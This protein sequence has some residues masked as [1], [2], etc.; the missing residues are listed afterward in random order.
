MPTVRVWDLPTRIFHALLVLAVV[1]LVVTAKIGGN[2]MEW[3]LRLG[4]AVL[5]LLLFRLLWGFLGGRWSR[6][7]QFIYRPAQVWAYLRGTGSPLHSIG[8]TPTGALSVF[9]MLGVLGAQV[10]SGLFSDDEIAFFGPL[11]RFVSADTVSLATHYHKAIGQWLLLGLIALH[12][13]AVAYYQW[14]RHQPLVG[15]MLHGDKPISPALG[16]VPAARD[17]WPQRLLALCLALCCIAVSAWV[18]G[19][20]TV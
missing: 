9:A 11:T 16:Q 13:L 2:W 12:L 17:G 8:H 1:A 4:H 3:H 20:G 7:A 19:L 6:F 10:G 15:A 14:V 18:A 5:A